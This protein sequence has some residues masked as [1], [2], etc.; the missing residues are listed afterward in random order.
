MLLPTHNLV[1]SIC[2]LNS[3]LCTREVGVVPYSYNNRRHFHR[4]PTFKLTLIV[5]SGPINSSTTNGEDPQAPQD[6]KKITNILVIFTVGSSGLHL[7]WFVLVC[8][9]GPHLHPVNSWWQMAVCWQL[10]YS[11]TCG[12]TVHLYVTIWFNYY[13]F[14]TTGSICFGSK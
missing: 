10:I 2:L 14:N 6:P 5:P 8:N 11:S 9:F 1:D 7:Y 12:C 13:I 4:C 3:I